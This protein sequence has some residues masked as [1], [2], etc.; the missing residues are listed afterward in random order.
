MKTKVV[1]IKS[2]N[3]NIKRT[4]MRYAVEK[5]RWQIHD[6]KRM[7]TSKKSEALKR[8]D[9]RTLTLVECQN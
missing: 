2:L 7:T 6:K 3:A 8:E 9:K 1:N 5:M 4:Q